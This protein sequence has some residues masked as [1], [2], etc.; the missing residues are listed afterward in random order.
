MKK[1]YEGVLR[2][3]AFWPTLGFT[4]QVG[5]KH[6]RLL[7]EHEGKKEFVL[8]GSSSSDFRAELNRISDVRHAAKR[9]G[10]IRL[11]K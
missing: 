10:A 11:D 8:F 5:K 4:F 2:E 3:L 7:L 9:L 1:R 6:T